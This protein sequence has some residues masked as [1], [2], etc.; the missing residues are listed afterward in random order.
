MP[1]APAATATST[2]AAP[3]TAAPTP[4]PI[5]VLDGEPWI[6]YGWPRVATDGL[7]AI[8][9]MRPDGSD[10]HEIAAEVPGEHKLPRWSPDG[11]R[12]AFVVQDGDHPEGSIWTANA[13]GS[14]AALL[15][16]GG[17]EC[18]VGLFHPAWSPDGTKL[19]VVC[20]PGG[21]DHESVAVLDLATTSIK[22]LAD[23][24]HPDAV[25]S[26]PSWSPDG[27]T[28][29]FEILHYDP[30]LTDLVG[31]V[32]AT[33]PVEGGKVHQLTNPDLFMVH[34]HW[35]PDGAELVMNNL[36][37][38]AAPGNLYAI[39][40]DGSGLDQLTHSSIDGHMRIETPRWDPDGSRILVS[41]VYTTGPDF[42]F[43]GEV[44]LAFVDGAGGEPE[45]IST[46]SGKYPD[47]RPTP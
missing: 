33:V 46:L 18:P 12:L 29:A 7:W 2:I 6:A 47:L 8:F 16:A 31:S 11:K 19:A 34:P 37:P 21:D 27:R 15:S 9:L 45:L 24:T 38:P 28:I 42:T 13:D 23:F 32:V 10:A 17:A 3:P 36:G 26:P 14:G 30:T 40:P 41:I 44:Q 22:R 35:S 4:T 20:Y 25:N 43:G 5:A 1:P 39:R